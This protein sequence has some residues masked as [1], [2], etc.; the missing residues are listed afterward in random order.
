MTD[1]FTITLRLD[2]EAET[3]DFARRVAPALKAGDVLLLRGDLGAGKTTFTRGLAVGMGSPAAVSSP[4]FTLIHEYGGGRLPLVHVDAYRLTG[5][6]DAREIGLVEYLDL[7]E[8]VLVIEWPERIEAALPP[9][10]IEI[11]IDE[12]G[13]DARRATLTW[14]GAR[15]RDRWTTVESA[16]SALPRC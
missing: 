10:R 9:E 13:D 3:L 4:T 11:R 12:W 2:T 6:G 8:A 7:G 1:D 15:F 14:V 16:L 5:A